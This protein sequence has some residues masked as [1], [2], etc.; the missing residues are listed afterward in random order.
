LL[1]KSYLSLIA[2]VKSLTS[3]CTFISCCS[4]FNDHRFFLATVVRPPLR[5][6]LI[7]SLPMVPVNIKVS[8]FEIYFTKNINCASSW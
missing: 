7:I 3:Y 6:L 1:P 8:D 4:V 2:Q 5:R